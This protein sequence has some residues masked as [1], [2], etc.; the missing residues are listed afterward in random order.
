[1]DLRYIAD[2]VKM[3]KITKG[4]N[5]RSIFKN[6]FKVNQVVYSSLPVYSTSFK[7]L[8]PTVFFRYFADKVKMQK[9]TKGHNSWS[10]FQNYSEI[11]QVI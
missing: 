6:L 3:S 4:H 8:D 2:K 10:I 7:A 1:M 11:N 5:S 9:I